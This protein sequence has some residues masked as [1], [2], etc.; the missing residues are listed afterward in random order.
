M[1][2][3]Y[4]QTREAMHAAQPK[5]APEDF[6]WEGFMSTSR[7]DLWS[8]SRV[9]CRGPKTIG[10]HQGLTVNE[11]PYFSFILGDLHA[12][13]SAL[14]LT[15][16]V[17]HILLALMIGKNESRGAWGAAALRTPGRTFL[18]CLLCGGL[19]FYNS[20]DA[21]PLAM[22]LA[23]FFFWDSRDWKRRP[24]Q[25]PAEAI[26]LLAVLLI[27]GMLVLFGPFS[28]HMKSPLI[29]GA[30]ASERLQSLIGLFRIS[31][32]ELP[33][34]VTELGLFWGLIWLPIALTL[35]PVLWQTIRRIGFNQKLGFLA[36]LCAFLASLLTMVF[37]SPSIAICLFMAA[38]SGA[39]AWREK[40]SDAERFAARLAF[41]GFV[42]VAAGEA[43]YLKDGMAD[44]H[45]RYNTVF[46]L[47]YPAW[48]ALTVSAVIL[49]WL[50][51]RRLG[52]AGR[53]LGREALRALIVVLLGLGFVYP[54]FATWA[55]TDGFHSIYDTPVLLPRA[56][57]PVESMRERTIDGLAY[58][59]STTP[60][61][62]AAIRWLL[63]KSNIKGRP[64]V[65]EAAHEKDSYCEIGRV[66]AYTGLP[67]V[68]GWI[69]HQ[70]QWRGWSLHGEFLNRVKDVR[71]IYESTDVESA[72]ALLLKYEID[73]VFVGRNER[74][75][76]DPEGLGK[77]F[78]ISEEAFRSG[79]TA[80][81]RLNLAAT[82]GAS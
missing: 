31:P 20:W 54:Y 1:A 81:Y 71:T 27:F 66:A 30:S 18:L 3:G 37:G 63:D 78:L 33:T 14:P 34:K 4:K 15:L 49:V 36:S 61:D 25:G 22:L 13:S 40:G 52:A 10:G 73:Y 67:T 28:H 75:R 32:W 62:L 43:F 39:L 24:F 6:T 82:G 51:W 8:A 16:V 64:R 19:Y 38:V 55:R 60:D 2:R 79:E 26:A 53:N 68:I 45:R 17:M 74:E 7:Y 65:L 48:A 57:R 47:Y 70:G 5:A 72:T 69:N 59:S 21:I 44:C 11:F 9:I 23:V 12:H 56:A 80:I 41:A 35:F 46:K 29:Q 42:I 58:L 76:Y 77:F 50:Q